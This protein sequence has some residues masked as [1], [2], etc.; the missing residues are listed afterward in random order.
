[1]KKLYK[2]INSQSTKDLEKEIV[3]LRGDIAKEALTMKVNP[4]KD[5]NSVFKKRKTLAVYLTVLSEKR[6]LETLQK[7]K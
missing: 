7:S 4:P 2:K 5:S 3:K 6:E 1:M